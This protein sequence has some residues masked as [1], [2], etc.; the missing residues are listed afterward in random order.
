MFDSAPLRRASINLW[1][2]G[3]RGESPINC[4]DSQP[5]N[6]SLLSP[7]SQPSTPFPFPLSVPWSQTVKTGRRKGGGFYKAGIICAPQLHFEHLLSGSR[8]I[9]KMYKPHTP[10]NCHY[11][12]SEHKH[13]MT[14]I[15]PS[16]RKCQQHQRLWARP[17]IYRFNK[18]YDLKYQ[19]GSMIDLKG[20]IHC[21]QSAQILGLKEQSINYL[22]N[23][24]I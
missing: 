24:K 20:L 13:P 6:W 8:G 3:L 11:V 22:Q 21:L 7:T 15:C 2:L 10:N 17:Y 19:H 4:L 14:S 12:L 9:S 16:F 1:T 23:W 18:P 5:K